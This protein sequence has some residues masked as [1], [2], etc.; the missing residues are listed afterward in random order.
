[1]NR[2]V[3]LILLLAVFIF[4][5]CERIKETYGKIK[6]G[7]EEQVQEA[8]VFAV[9]ITN[10]VQGQIQDYIALSGDIIAGSTVDAYSD[11]AGKVTQ[12]YVSVGERVNRGDAIAA[13]DPSRPGMTF[14]Q[15]I[16][17]APIS[18]TIVALPAQVGMTITQAVPLARISG[19]GALE[20]R[21]YVA[22][23]FISKMAMNLSCEITLDAWPGE[24]FQGSISEVSPTVDAASR[25]M[26]VKVNVNN[27]GSKLKAGMFAKVKIITERKDGIVKIPASAVI[28]RFGEQYVFAVDKTD[29]ENP[30]A[31]RKVIVPGILIDGVMEIQQG[32]SPNEETVVR[33]QT[34][35]E[36]GSRIRIIDQLAPLSAN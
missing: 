31:R 20:I 12:L 34:L 32:L 14:R 13:V 3:Y 1:M 19:G 8:P 15:S 5:G 18:G 24:I 4:S 35:L 27:A 6:G 30:V 11:A 28:N 2:K 26:E 33:G 9:N 36:D 23:R 17:T 7:K 21:L 16:V 22:E 25:T 29:P 10:A